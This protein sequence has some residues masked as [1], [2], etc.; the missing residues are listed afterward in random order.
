M[1]RI[2]LL[3][4]L[5]VCAS[6]AIGVAPALAVDDQGPPC[7]NIALDLAN[8]SYTGTLGGT[9]TI[10]GISLTTAKPACKQVDYFVTVNGVDY[11]VTPG[12]NITITL[13]NAPQSVALS[14]RSQIG[15]HVADSAPDAGP[16][17]LSTLQLNPESSPGGGYFG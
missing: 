17:P 15:G 5:A 9:A 12:T 13:D 4:L 16:N 1:R 3:T 6:I 2:T 7:A 11:Q 10:T 14:A 8:A